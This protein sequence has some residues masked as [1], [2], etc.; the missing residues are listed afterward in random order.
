MKD[1]MKVNPLLLLLGSV[2]G[3]I[4]GTMLVVFPTFAHHNFA[5]HYITDQNMTVTGV[6][7]EFRMVNPHARVYIDVKSDNG[8][9]VSWMAEGDASVAL[10]RSGWANDELKPGDV[11]QI[12]GNPSRVGENMMGW[13]NII[14]SDGS[15]IGGGDGRLLERVE[16]LEA[17]LTKYRGQR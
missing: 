5:A 14:L 7:T 9:V 15:E 3:A 16:I 10:R 6:V 13:N 2:F 12:H 17:S 1:A 11:I 8:E 4:F